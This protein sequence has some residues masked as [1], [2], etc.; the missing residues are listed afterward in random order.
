[1]DQDQIADEYLESFV[2]SKLNLFTL[3]FFSQL[4]S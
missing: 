2:V 4:K 3:G 1:M